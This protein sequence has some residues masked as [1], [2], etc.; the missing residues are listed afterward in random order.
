MKVL[1]NL[2]QEVDFDMYPQIIKNGTLTFKIKVQSHI[3]NAL[4]S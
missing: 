1:K 2:L 3:A 4:K